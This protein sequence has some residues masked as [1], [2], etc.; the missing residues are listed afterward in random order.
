MESTRFLDDVDS[1][2][3]WQREKQFNSSKRS[4]YKSLILHGSLITF[5]SILFL[6]AMLKSGHLTTNHDVVRDM[7]SCMYL[8]GDFLSDKKLT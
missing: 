2:E 4:S 6:F 7:V 5:Y 1:P 8:V 3:K